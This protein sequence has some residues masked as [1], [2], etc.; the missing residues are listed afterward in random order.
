MAMLQPLL[1][2]AQFSMRISVE[3]IQDAEQRINPCGDSVL[4]LRAM[5]IP[6]IENLGTTKD[7]FAC[8][9]LSDNDIV[10]IPS[11]PRMTRLRT[12]LLGNNAISQIT[13]HAFDSLPN[14]TS[15]VLSSNK[16][17]HLCDI[18]P[19]SNLKRLERLS[20]L[21]NPVTKEPHYRFLVIHLMQYALTF[22][23]LDFQRITDAER[24]EA[25]AFFQTQQGLDLMRAVTPVG[26]TKEEGETKPEKPT[27]FSREMM[28]KIQKCLMAATDLNQINI[29]EDALKRGEL[30][31]AA[32]ELVL[33]Q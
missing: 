17:S 6:A 9:D 2:H 24:A 13:A 26:Q 31:K 21:E 32:E 14:L 8:I 29:L 16:V 18:Y 7:L 23:Y 12:L 25:R 4:V 30:T 15:L 3:L 10:K 11:I 19:I 5:K 22:R 27:G 28:D 20:L 33:K 1:A